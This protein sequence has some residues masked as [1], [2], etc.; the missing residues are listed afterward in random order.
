MERG[1]GVHTVPAPN[2]AGWVNELDGVQ[3]G[4]VQKHKITATTI[5]RKLAVKHRVEH[6]IHLKDGRIGSK[7]SYGND[8]RD[9]KG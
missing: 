3:Q 5:G 9:V 6:T 8:P 1:K 7:N 2:G 4:R